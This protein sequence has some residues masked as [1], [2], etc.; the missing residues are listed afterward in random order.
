MT[1]DLLAANQKLLQMQAKSRQARLDAGQPVDVAQQLPPDFK[2]VYERRPIDGQR[3]LMY[4][5]EHHQVMD[6][7]ARTLF[8][9]EFA[10]RCRQEAEKARVELAI[11]QAAA[12]APETAVLPELVKVYPSLLV[13]FLQSRQAAVGRVYQLFRAYDTHTSGP[14]WLQE[15]DARAL[16]TDG[17]WQ[18]MTWRRLRQILAAGEGLVWTRD[19]CGRVWLHGPARIAKAL[20]CGRMQGHPVYLPVAALL[21][22]MQQVRAHFYAS[23]HSG[24]GKE[25]SRPA[26]VSREALEQLTGVKERSQRDY[27]Q[28]ARVVKVDNLATLGIDSDQ[29]RQDATWKHGRAVFTIV[30]HLGLQ[31]QKGQRRLMQKLPNAYLPAHDE[32]PR[33]RQKTINKQ[34]GNPVIYEG[35][36]NDGAGVNR[37][38]HRNGAQ[39]A[40]A[41]LRHGGD[42]PTYY[43]LAGGIGGPGAPGRANRQDWGAY[44]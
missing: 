13:G 17:P 27:D 19:D 2:L 11:K 8:N 40:R 16:L 7:R 29:A 34:I 33:G 12:V 26:P 20:G 14:G 38:F 32:A 25:G 22:G 3:E 44:V 10:E 24:R 28:V 37:I 42:F 35:R 18:V 31:G 41:H 9:P 30:D 1:P 4:Q 21:G 15:D 39:A 23:W 5:R 43:P 6:V 36:G